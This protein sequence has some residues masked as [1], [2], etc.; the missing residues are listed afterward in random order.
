[1]L[2]LSDVQIKEMNVIDCVLS[3]VACGVVP[4]FKDTPP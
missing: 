3:S 4:P 2:A 1:M